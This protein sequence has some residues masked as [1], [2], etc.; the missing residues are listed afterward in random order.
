MN[1]NK[2]QLI[3]RVGKD[4]VIKVLESGK[5]A[6]FSLAT[7]EKWKES[8]EQKEHTEWHNIT[9][10]GVVA[11]LAEQYVKRGDLL[12]I[13]GK[14]Q[15]REYTDKE[16]NKRSITNVIGREFGFLSSKSEQKN[17]EPA[18]IEPKPT[19]APEEPND[20]PW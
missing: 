7:T 10:F 20:L 5:I 11:G 17:S 14:I 6:S 12:Y 2:I 19:E 15:T 13:E 9:L 8:G 16:G 3:G 18:H 4:P 1:L